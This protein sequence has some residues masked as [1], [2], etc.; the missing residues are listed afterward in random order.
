MKQTY[1][2]CVRDKTLWCLDASVESH[3]QMSD[4]CWHMKIKSRQLLLT[5][6][7]ELNIEALKLHL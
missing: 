3:V 7:K 2:D 1:R 5:H 4:K 6:G